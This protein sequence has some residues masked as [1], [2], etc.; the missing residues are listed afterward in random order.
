[1]LLQAFIAQKQVTYF[2]EK[3]NFFVLLPNQ[4]PICEGLWTLLSHLLFPSPFL[5]CFSSKIPYF[6][7]GGKTSESG[8]FDPTPA[9]AAVLSSGL[10]MVSRVL[11]CLL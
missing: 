8:A 7:S 1:M 9:G 5:C 11:V 2:H 10:E 4:S 6:S 3:L